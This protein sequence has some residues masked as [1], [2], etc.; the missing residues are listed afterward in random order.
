MLTSALL[1]ST[2]LVLGQA[3]E[4]PSRL[5][6]RK[7]LD[8]FTGAWKMELT[9]EA[10][11]P[12]TL[13]ASYEWILNRNAQLVTT[14]AEI[15]DRAQVIYKELRGWDADTKQIT[16]LGFRMGG[17]HEEKVT[18]IEAEKVV[19][20]TRRVRADGRTL[21]FTQTI[22]FKDRDTI[23]NEITDRRVGEEQRDDVTI[24]WKRVE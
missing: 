11:E 10:G 17:G 12:L 6:Y 19:T 8:R 5:D 15:G 21:S 2:S 9:T 7:T 20:K 3:E 14:S 13:L 24:E 18:T 4:P 22:T 1:I 23:I 16:G